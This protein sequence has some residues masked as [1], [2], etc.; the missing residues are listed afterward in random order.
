MCDVMLEKGFEVM[1]KMQASEG[2]KQFFSHPTIRKWWGYT[3]F[4]TPVT[5]PGSVYH[6][7][8]ANAII[9]VLT[10]HQLRLTKSDFMNDVSEIEYETFSAA[11]MIT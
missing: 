11:A 2:Q 8:S 7:T 3:D 6:Y 4:S 10:K 1:Q 5:N 9:N